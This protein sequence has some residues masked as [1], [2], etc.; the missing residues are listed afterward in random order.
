MSDDKSKAVADRKRINIH[1]DYEMR[2]WS[3]RLGVSRDE[4]KRAVSKVGMMADDVARELGKSWLHSAAP[5]DDV[6]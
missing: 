1:E 2:Y 3:H 6:A 5:P 4:L